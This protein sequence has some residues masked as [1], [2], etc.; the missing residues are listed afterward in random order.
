[1]SIKLKYIPDNLEEILQSDE[2]ICC[3]ISNVFDN[4]MLENR[5]FEY[6]FERRYT[7]RIITSKTKHCTP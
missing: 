5:F 2:I 3:T 6:D 4:A 7:H 1:M